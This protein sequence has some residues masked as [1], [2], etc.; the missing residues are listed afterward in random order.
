MTISLRSET[1]KLIRLADRDLARLWRLVS[2][3]ASAEIALRDLLPAIVAEYGAAGAAMAA[4]W[5]DQQRE[6]SG[7]KGRFTAL[8]VAADDRG[9]QALVG[10]A[11]ATATDDISLA[12][13]VAGGVQRRIADHARYTVARNSTE[14]PGSDGWQR[15]GDGS[16]CAF[17]NM[18]I[19]R[20]SVYSEAVADFASHD[21]CGCSA[22]PAF[23]GEPRPVKPYT[24]SPRRTI[25]PE[26]DKPTIDADFLRAK[27]W[28][29]SH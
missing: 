3:G 10:W 4:E 27:A 6:K 1:A 24:V 29:A 15:V 17:C 16:S 26:T 13:L 7:A 28:V 19:G 12:S 18:L 8:P 20:G 2:Q 25:D 14:D 21:N 11:L 22:A 5:Y 9:A 23:K